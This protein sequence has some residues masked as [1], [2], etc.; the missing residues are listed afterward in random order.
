MEESQAISRLQNGDLGGLEFLVA[1]YQAQAVQAACLIVQDRAQAEDIVQNAFIVAAEK[2]SQ[3]DPERPFKPWFFRSVVNASIKAA[4]RQKRQVYLDE[5][6]P[7]R[8]GVSMA[9]A[10]ADAQPLP[11]E[12]LERQQ[13]RAAV[14][15]AIDQL[16]P[17]QRAV[18][19][20]RYF[21][22][23][24]ESEMG[25]ELRRPKSTVKYW[26]RGA[27]KQLKRLLHSRQADA[28][29]KAERSLP[30]QGENKKEVW[31]G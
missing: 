7:G 22:E 2:I 20:M 1:R 21:L 16:A 11:E 26:L 10:L 19:V 18:I 5:S 31:H 9:D 4:D 6:E 17:G 28:D 30:A 8:G 13:D 3:Y 27:R 15:Q 14:M 24:N 23:M 12:W 29:S 25:E